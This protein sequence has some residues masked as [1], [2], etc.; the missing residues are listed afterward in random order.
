MQPDNKSAMT[1]EPTSE[2]TP[3]RRAADAMLL[4]FEHSALKAMLPAGTEISDIETIDMDSVLPPGNDDFRIIPSTHAHPTLNPEQNR[5]RIRIVKFKQGFENYEINTKLSQVN[6][7]TVKRGDVVEIKTIVGSI[8]LRILDR[9]K[10]EH[11]GIGEILCE[12]R[13][14]LMDQ[15]AL[16]HAASITLPVCTKHHVIENADGSR[17][18]AS[19]A[20]K[21]KTEED[22][23]ENIKSLLSEKFF[24]EIV[25]YSNPAPEKF[26][27]VDVM[28]WLMRVA[29]KI[30][31][32]IEE[33]NRMEREKKER[34]EEEKRRKKEERQRAKEDRNKKQKGQSK[35]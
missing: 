23:P 19:R 34:K 28:R 3:E 16:V 17:R 2:K 33:N 30:K 1:V 15:W 27:F 13:Y 10:G 32:V 12:C 6:I 35:D 4:K 9:I 14:D 8:F 25:L 20:L 21:M 18:F 29:R 24:T 11:P 7:L 22:L 5:E 26:R 31:A